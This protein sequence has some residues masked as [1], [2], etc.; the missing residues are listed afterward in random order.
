MQALEKLLAERITFGYRVLDDPALYQDCVR[1]KIH[2]AVTP[3]VS[4]ANRWRQE[5]ME[6]DHLLSPQRRAAL[7]RPPPGCPVR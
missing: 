7:H 5:D 1:N 4:L 6:D 2:F 3:T